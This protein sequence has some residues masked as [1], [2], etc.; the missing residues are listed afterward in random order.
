MSSHDFH[1]LEWSAE[2][3]F[4]ETEGDR[5]VV[6]AFGRDVEGSTCSASF[7]HMPTFLV[8][9][10]GADLS[11]VLDAVVAV[12]GDEVHDSSGVVWGKP[13]TGWIDEPV[14]FL[15]LFFLTK[16][17][18][19]NAGKLFK[20]EIL[21]GRALWRCPSWF[22]ATR[23][24]VI[25]YELESD[26]LLQALHSRGIPTTGWVRADVAPT[27]NPRARGSCCDL[28]FETTPAPLTDKE[29]PE[30]NAPHVVATF[31]IECFSSRSVWEDQIF[32]EATFPGDCVTQVV[33]YLNRFGEKTPFD[34]EALVLL[35]K[36]GDDSRRP[37]TL[38]GGVVPVRVRYFN[39][40]ADLLRAWVQ[41][42]ASNKVSIWSHFNGLG[43]DEPYLFNRCE[44]LAVDLSPLSFAAVDKNPSLYEHV[45]ESNA[46]GFNQFS[47]IQL[48]GVL[49]VDV[50]A[51]IKK[52]TNLEGYSLDACAEHFLPNGVRKAD[53]KPQEQFDC[54]RNNEVQKLLEYC[55]QDVN[56]TWMLAEKLS[57]V[58]SLVETAAIAGVTCTMVATRGQQV[59]VYSCILREIVERGVNLFLKDSKADSPAEG[60]YKGAT[61]LEP[62]VGF[63]PRAVVSLDFASLYPTIIMQYNLSH[64]TWSQR[65]DTDQR[66]YNHAEGC[67]FIKSSVAGQ[68]VLPSILIKLAASRKTY[69]KSMRKFETLAFGAQTTEDRDKYAFMERLYD[70]KQKATKVG[71]RDSSTSDTTKIE[72]NFHFVGF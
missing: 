49:H 33:F 68:G 34:A 51:D 16:R 32:P 38:A 35:A 57:V 5:F 23:L 25:T 18:M 63:Y 6:T 31:D 69:K 37:A 1:V 3:R 61:V 14:A 52:S 27:V 54:F 62:N 26:S 55:T 45:L 20:N 39:S 21:V 59:R 70:A 48:A 9:L 60:G 50:M 24:T 13:F 58:P 19:R 17:A 28:H 72:N 40:E 2:D 56:I 15:R 43:F 7:V 30:A 64:E 11:A 29:R 65:M 22:T 41:S 4:S 53:L 10:E 47:T 71:R 42:F 12:C 44:M 36:P 67:S 46:Y 66:F 8:R